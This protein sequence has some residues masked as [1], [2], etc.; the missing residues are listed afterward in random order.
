MPHLYFFLKKAHTTSCIFGG[1]TSNNFSGE[2]R[3]RTFRTTNVVASGGK[4]FMVFGFAF[5]NGWS[6]TSFSEPTMLVFSNLVAQCQNVVS[7]FIHWCIKHQ[8]GFLGGFCECPYKRPPYVM[9][10]GHIHEVMPQRGPITKNLCCKR[11][12]QSVILSFNGCIFLEIH[13]SVNSGF[14]QC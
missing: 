6:A 14:L 11:I 8:K 10:A 1:R 13:A 12:R 7:I 3:A 9:H 2:S 4:V 5:G